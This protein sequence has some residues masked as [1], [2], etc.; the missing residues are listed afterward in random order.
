MRY[1]LQIS[2]SYFCLEYSWLQILREKLGR[3]LNIWDWW[4]AK[5]PNNYDKYT[6]YKGKK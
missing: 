2:F 1:S 3:Q 5:A 4:I 6:I